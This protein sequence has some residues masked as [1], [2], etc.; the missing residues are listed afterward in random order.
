MVIDQDLVRLNLL[1]RAMNQNPHRLSPK[2]R[3]IPYL[4]NKPRHTYIVEVR[5]R[6]AVGVQLHRHLTSAI[7]LASIP[8]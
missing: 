1:I 6:V 5:G 2:K 7:G 3:D 4:G 8:E